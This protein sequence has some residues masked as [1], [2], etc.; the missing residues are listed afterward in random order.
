MGVEI[1]WNPK[2]NEFEG[3]RANE[4]GFLYKDDLQ[5]G[6]ACWAG[7]FNGKDK[8]ENAV[9]RFSCPCGCKALG[10]IPLS[11]WEK[12]GWTW[13]GNKEKP[14]LSPSIRM[15]TPCGWHGYLRKG[16]FERC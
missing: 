4:Q 12:N 16:V 13:D 2:A 7:G 14:T 1:K 9:L 3:T 10:G 15:L 8:I 11:H 5:P 6:D